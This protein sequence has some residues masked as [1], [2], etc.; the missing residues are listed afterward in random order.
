MV[1]DIAIIG[2][3]VVGTQIARNFSKYDLK[4]VLLEKESDVAMGTTKANSGIVHAGFD[5]QSGTMMADLNVKGCRMM[6]EV[7]TTL[8]VPYEKN[9]SLVVAFSEEE[10]ETIKELYDR[11]ITNGLTEDELQI[12]DREK[13][14]ELEPHIA[15]NA[16]GALYA[17]TAGIVSPYE[18]AIGAAECAVGNG[19]EFLRTFNVGGIIFEDGMFTIGAKDGRVIRSKWV[20]NAGGLFANIIAD[21]FNNEKFKVIPRIG[22]YGLLDR[23]VYPLVTHTVFQCP[24]KMGKGILVAPTTHHNVFVGPTSLDMEDNMDGRHD[25]GVRVGALRETYAS[26]QKSIPSVSARDQITSFAGLRAHWV[27]HDFY[28]NPA[29]NNDHFINLIGIESPGLAASPA[30][31]EYVENMVLD[32]MGEKPAE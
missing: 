28:I 20:I 25:V 24:S 2:A 18:L 6:E 31:A 1:Y 17:P 15:D 3:G 32:I 7:A 30:I 16:V 26:A 5:C 11:G 14:M 19:V 21:N 8:H 23:D 4:T 9:G 27:E 22:E 12:I 29:K 10:M 13:L